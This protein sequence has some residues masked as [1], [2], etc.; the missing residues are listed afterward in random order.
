MIFPQIRHPTGIQSRL[1]SREGAARGGS[2]N[3]I[4]A[5]EGSPGYDH[6]NAARPHFLRIHPN[7]NW[8]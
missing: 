6:G 8:D 4:N 5:A 2:T 3:E 1:I 7:P